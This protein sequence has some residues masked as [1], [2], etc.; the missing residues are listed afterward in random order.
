MVAHE[1]SLVF[2]RSPD[3]TSLMIS[4]TNSLRTGL[5]FVFVKRKLSKYD[6][7]QVFTL[8]PPYKRHRIYQTERVF[9]AGYYWPITNKVRKFARGVSCL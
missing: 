5:E 9:I 2:N 3:F 6:I 4:E 7:R 1:W 8:R